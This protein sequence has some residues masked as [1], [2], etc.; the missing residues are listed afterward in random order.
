MFINFWQQKK[1]ALKSL[2]LNKPRLGVE[3]IMLI[4]HIFFGSDFLKTLKQTVY[5]LDHQTSGYVEAFKL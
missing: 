2:N 3:I 4:K 1:I 5:H